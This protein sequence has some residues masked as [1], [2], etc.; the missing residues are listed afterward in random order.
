[1]S[2]YRGPEWKADNAGI[3]MEAVLDFDSEKL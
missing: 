3:M 1:M 2:C